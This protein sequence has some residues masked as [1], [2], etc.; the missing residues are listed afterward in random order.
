MLFSH[1]VMSDSC[2]SMDYK[3]LCPWDFPGKNTGW[4]CHFL[5]QGIFPTQGLNLCLLHWQTYSL[6]PSHLG[7]PLEKNSSPEKIL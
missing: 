5:L 6:L 4:S 1:E 7:N 2:D 3:L